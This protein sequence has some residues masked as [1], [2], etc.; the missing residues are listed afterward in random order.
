MPVWG[1]IFYSMS[2]DTALETMRTKNLVKYLESLQV[3]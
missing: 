3:K 2:K 1:H